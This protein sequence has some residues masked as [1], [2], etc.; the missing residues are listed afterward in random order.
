MVRYWRN[1]D[2]RQSGG[3]SELLLAHLRSLFDVGIRLGNFVQDVDVD[4]VQ[5]SG[6]WKRRRVRGANWCAIVGS[7]IESIEWHPSAQH[8]WNVDGRHLNTVDGQ[9]SS[10]AVTIGF[11]QLPCDRVVAGRKW[12]RSTDLMPLEREVIVEGRQAILDEHDIAAPTVSF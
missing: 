4:S 10:T 5:R 6:E 1:P 2:E 3:T 7:D 12:L 11:C 9:C 8:S